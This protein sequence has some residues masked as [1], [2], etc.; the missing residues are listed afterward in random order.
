MELL[1]E[2]YALESSLTPGTAHNIAENL[3]LL[4]A[5]FAP[6]TAQ[7]LWAELGHNTPVFR[8]SWPKFDAELAREDLIEIPVQ[9]NGKLRGHIK[10]AIGSSK[11]ELEGLARN[12][13][14]VKPFLEGKQVVKVVVVV[15]RLVNFVVK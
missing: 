6:Y 14:R 4:L 13:E 9:V 5:P 7:D 12:N 1:N 3:T 15:D 8:E 11:D 2:F 10:A